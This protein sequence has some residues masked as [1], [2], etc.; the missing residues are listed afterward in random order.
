MTELARSA[1]VTGGSGFIGGRLIPRL[2][3]RGWGGRAL[4]RSAAAEARVEALGAQAVHGDLESGAALRAG[5]HGCAYAFH[6]AAHLGASGDRAAFER[7]NVEGTKKAL[8]ACRDAEVRRF[9]HV[10]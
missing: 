6:A 2:V 1:F 7:V 5:A 4:A 9:V 10:G 8:A 3:A